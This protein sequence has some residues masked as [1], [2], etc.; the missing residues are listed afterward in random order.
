MRSARIALF[1]EWRDWCVGE[2]REHAGTKNVFFRDLHA[3]YP[4]LVEKRLRQEGTA[5]RERLYT[6]IGLRSP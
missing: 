6:G 1:E 4:G 3:A 2:G 5:R